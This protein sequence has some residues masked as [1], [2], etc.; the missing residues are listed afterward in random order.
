MR[1]TGDDPVELDRLGGEVADLLRGISGTR[2]IY[3]SWAIDSPEIR[4]VVDRQR[5][6]EFGLSGE[7]IA[8]ATYEAVEGIAV[9]PFRQ[10]A[11]RIWISPCVM[12]NPTAGPSR[13]W[14]ASMCRGR[15]A[16]SIR[17]ARSPN[18][19]GAGPAHR[20]PGKLSENARRARL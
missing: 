18:W 7:A 12:S 5:A 17:S 2:N 16:I 15:T 14:A 3:R 4:V 9:T 20:H 11:D 6:G 19:R 13:S 8:A 1:L 10:P